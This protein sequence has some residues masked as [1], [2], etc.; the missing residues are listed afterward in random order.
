MKRIDTNNKTYIE[1][2]DN[3]ILIKDSEDKIIEQ[4]YLNDGDITM[5]VNLLFMMRH[6]DK[7]KAYLFNF[8]EEETESHFRSW[9][10][11]GDLMEYK[12]LNN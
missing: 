12:I 3:D 6:T 1:I 8:K 5:I 10:Y 2:R 11:N 7:T 9:L 4:L